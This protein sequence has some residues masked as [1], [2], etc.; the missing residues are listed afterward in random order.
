[1]IDARF[2]LPR[3]RHPA[4]GERVA[5]PS[6]VAL[7]ADPS[8]AT[9]PGIFAA[10]RLLP[11]ADLIAGLRALQRRA[12][13][14]AMAVV[15]C[16]GSLTRVLIRHADAAEGTLYE[17][18]FE[19][20][21]LS[22]TI[23]PRHQHLHIAIAD[24]EGR[25]FGGHLLPGSQVRTTAEIVALILPG[26]RFGRAPCPRSGYDELTIAAEEAP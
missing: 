15:A 3:F 6:P 16:A 5:V 23:D 13:A 10:L 14:P 8:A 20:T 1:M 21:S 24:P 17:G 11:G 22:G 26:L 12:D 25:V 9:S 7:A 4:S 19:I 2:G 18:R